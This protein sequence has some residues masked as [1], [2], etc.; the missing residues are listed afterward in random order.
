MRQPEPVES[1][2]RRQAKLVVASA[3]ALYFELL[4]VRWTNAYVRNVGFF[5]N[6]LVLASFVGLGA[7]LLLA[8]RKESLLPFLPLTALAYC[9]IV[10]VGRPRLILHDP[11]A[12]F[13]GDENEDPLALLSMSP[14]V[15]V[16]IAF[17]I[18]VVM[19]V[20]LGQ[21]IGRLFLGLSPLHA[22]ALN[23][24]GALA[25][26]LL[27]TAGS[28]VLVHPVVW[29]GLALGGVTWLVWASE[30]RAPALVATGTAL[31]C[32]VVVGVMNAGSLWSPYYRTEILP[33]DGGGWILTGNGVVGMGLKP[34]ERKVE[35]YTIPYGEGGLVKRRLFRDVLVIGAGGG[36]DVDVAL[37]YGAEHVDA[38]EIN[39]L[40]VQVGRELHPDRPY[41]SPRVSAFV[42][43]GR[44]F[45]RHSSHHYDLI[46]YALPDSLGVVSSYANMRVESYLFTLEA[47]RAARDHLNPDG[48]FVLYNQYRE[49]WLVEKIARM[50]EAEFG[51]PSPF[52][53]DGRASI[54]AA[55]FAG[56]GV[57]DLAPT[58]AH[59][60]S[61]ASAAIEPASDD[62][63]FLYLRGRGVPALY[64]RSLAVIA[65]LSF[66]VVA[67]ALWFARDGGAASAAVFRLNAPLFFMGAGFML[68]EAKCIVTFGLLFGTTWLTTALVVSGIL[69]MVLAAIYV[70]HRFQVGRVWP[71]GL[72]LALAL[73]LV[74]AVPPETLVIGNPTLRYVVGAACALSPVMFANVLFA[75]LFRE[76]VDATA[77]LA[78]NTL[79]GVV[80][81]IAEYAA[82]VTGYR[83]L[84]LVVAAFY[85][86]AFL[87]RARRGTTGAQMIAGS[88]E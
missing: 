37:Q 3:V 15:F 31:A 5:T 57:H 30:A 83:R 67:L 9:V 12:L 47:F 52:L 87:L 22:Y 72:A 27:F 62:W 80:G 81:G 58:P 88:T 68:L 26:A 49:L 46:V 44:A 63:P 56:P 25:G 70:N 39:P 2:A 29:F 66:A 16:A 32:L 64:V 61:A 77:A 51:Q 42:D 4:V 21:A 24:G 48:V 86:L 55:I 43:D 38:V 60:A 35:L 84:L 82:L 34:F 19:F 8:R 75:R 65:A 71:W 1:L 69:A 11:A 20:M 78:S 45:L 53:V 50:L 7:G 14:E 41:A 54:R 36:N 13:W 79:G 18:V 23:V 74:Y 28:F 6:F 76:T 73:G 10:W 85:G 40:A 33:R 17:V 59:T